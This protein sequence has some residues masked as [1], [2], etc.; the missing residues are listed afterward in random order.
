MHLSHTLSTGLCGAAFFIL[1]VRAFSGSP[2]T[3]SL[4]P[5]AEGYDFDARQWISVDSPRVDIW[6][7]GLQTLQVKRGYIKDEGSV[8]LDS[9]KTFDHTGESQNSLLGDIG[10]T[11][12]FLSTDS[13]PVVARIVLIQERL[14][15]R[16]T[17]IYN[18]LQTVQ[19][20]RSANREAAKGLTLACDGKNVITC[21]VGNGFEV[22]DLSLMVFSMNGKLLQGMPV[23]SQ[24]TLLWRLPEKLTGT[25]GAVLYQKNIPLMRRL[26]IVIR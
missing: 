24:K 23:I 25:Y 22:R 9:V 1:S 10:H 5:G 15:V 17:Y 26:I 13:A 2:A 11:Y 6:S 19:A 14:Q 12:T 8:P 20:Q 3:V 4:I 18:Y 16:L 7:Y 21:N